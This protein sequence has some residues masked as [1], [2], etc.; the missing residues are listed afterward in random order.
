MFLWLLLIV[1]YGVGCCMQS[2]SIME[3]ADCLLDVGKAG[4]CLRPFACFGVGRFVDAMS[5]A[6]TDTEAQEARC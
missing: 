2:C 4:C 1:R 3:F 5:T 6:K